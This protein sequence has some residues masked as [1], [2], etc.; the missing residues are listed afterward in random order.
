MSNIVVLLSQAF[1]LICVVLFF[2]GFFKWIQYA[3]YILSHLKLFKYFFSFSSKIKGIIQILCIILLLTVFSGEIWALST[4]KIHLGGCGSGTQEIRS[5]FKKSVSSINQAIT[6]NYALENKV[7]MGSIE[8]FATMFAKRMSIIDVRYLAPFKK[9]VRDYKSTPDTYKYETVEYPYKEYS[10]KEIKDY[11]LSEFKG[12]PIIQTADGI[13]YMFK[14]FNPGCKFVDTE[15]PENSDCIMVVDVNG[16]KK[17]NEMTTQC[18]RKKHKD[19]YEVVVW[20]NEN[21]ATVLNKE[22]QKIFFDKPCQ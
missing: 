21:K 14:K 20:G 8:E 22:Q 10:E 2:F 3:I 7:D 11:N 19:R 1:F 9:E 15:N 17:P 16:F 12:K 5:A 18:E 4:G 13:L 6:Y